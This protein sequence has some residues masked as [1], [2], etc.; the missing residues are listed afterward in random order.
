MSKK[1]IEY[2]KP[3]VTVDIVVFT[4]KDKDLKI[5]LIKRN[6]EPF[7]N[8][9]A[10]PGGF[11][12]KGETLE[13]AAIRELSEETNVKDIY[14][15]QLYS[16]GD[17]DRDPRGWVVTIAYYALISSENLNLL[18]STDAKDVKWFS[19]YDLPKLAFDHAKI[20]ETA[21]TRLRSKLEYTNVALELLPKKFTLTQ[22]QNTHEIILNKTLDKR[23][24]RKRILSLNVIEPAD[25][26]KRD[27]SHRPARLYTF[28]NEA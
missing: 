27:G 6:L 11:V 20:L 21:L 10:I 13:H 18:A 22:L 9:W 7:K 17:P 16:F 2:E 5:L 12:L 4:I 19:I 1:E 14:L 25:E 3:S 23:N 28:K 15:E 24:F 26:F 8:M